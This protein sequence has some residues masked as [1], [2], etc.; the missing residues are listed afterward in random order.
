MNGK[1][2]V[3][4]SKYA[5]KNINATPAVIE[6]L[7][8]LKGSKD[9][10]LCFEQGEYHFFR[11]GSLKRFF[12]VSNNTSCD[13]YVIFP[14]IDYNGITIDGGGACFVFH[15]ITFPFIVQ[16]SKN[17]TI[18]NV[19]ADCAYSPI[20]IFTVKDKCDESFKLIFDRE[21]SPFVIEDGSLNFV[22][23]L[24]I[25]SGKKL[26]Y[27]LHAVDRIGVLYL[28][29]GDCADEKHGLAA[30]Y[31]L[32]DAE[33]IKGGVLLTYRN[34]SPIKCGFFEN[35]VISTIVDGGR[36]VDVIF[37]DDSENIKI[38]N[39]TVRQGIGMGVIAQICRNIEID[40]FSTDVNYHNGVSTLTADSL[41]FVNCSGKINIHDCNISH[42]MDDV[43]NVHGMYTVLKEIGDGKIIA[44]I[45]HHEQH[46]V[47]VYRAGDSL[48]ILDNK[49]FKSVAQFEVTDSLF[50]DDAETEIELCGRFI[51]GEEFAT[52]GCL[53]ENSLKIA[54]VHIHDNIFHKYPRILALGSGDIIIENNHLSH[55]VSALRSEVAPDYWYESGALQNLIFRNNIVDNCNAMGGNAFISAGIEGFA[56]NN[57][58]KVHK[59]FEISGNTFKNILRHAICVAGI[60]ELV[61]KDNVF[62][63]KRDDL[64]IVDGK[65]VEI[66]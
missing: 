45:S 29:T 38:Q 64:I 2:I 48:D 43:V 26:K 30:P 62:D 5:D 51:K 60:E 18:K 46:H 6:A 66:Q 7:E 32:T 12:A 23:E 10:I 59:R 22:R 15:E 54:E 33:E 17:V 56:R 14:I 44:K 37:L 49:T 58:P 24:G 36:E 21:K 27:S 9:A 39:V 11:E 31:M 40:N 16:N 55:S 4:S 41:H 13:K 61:V 42:T 65:T 47:N 53:I 3:I 34:D 63:S 28:F 35:E 50:I 1:K 57:T 20:C 19:T 25:R 52:S 8:Q